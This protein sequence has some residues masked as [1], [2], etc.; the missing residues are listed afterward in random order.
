MCNGSSKQFSISYVHLLRSR[1][2]DYRITK[3]SSSFTGKNHYEV[4]GVN[5]NAT[6]KEIKTAFYEKS[7]L[8]HPDNSNEKSSTEFV[9]LKTAYDILRRPADRRLYDHQLRNGFEAIRR[10]FRH[11][12]SGFRRAE[13]QYDFSRDWGKHWREHQS[14]NMR[15]SD[16]AKR[17]EKFWKTILMWTAFG[18]VVVVAYNVGYL[19]MLKRR[20]KELSMLVDEEEIAKSFLRQK[21]FRDANLDSAEVESLA[22]LLK[23]D[24][25]EA[26]RN[27]CELM[28]TRNRDEIREEYRWFR[29]VQDLD[30]T[31]RIQSA[32]ISKRRQERD[33]WRK[34][35]D[36]EKAE[37]EPAS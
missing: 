10:D 7:K 32:R 11:P 37:D 24:I 29:A 25:D 6:L 17:N 30:H 9:E 22:R 4:L 2:I 27:R 19:M 18:V 14:E 3:Q 5:K 13:P 1:I 21:E 34:T 28:A 35:N 12:Y 16:H 23:A 31:R 33:K 26:W 36:D 20:E 8:L 15:D